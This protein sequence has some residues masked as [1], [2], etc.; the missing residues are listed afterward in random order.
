MARLEVRDVQTLWSGT[1]VA[2]ASATSGGHNWWNTSNAFTS[3]ATQV[4][5]AAWFKIPLHGAERCTIFWD[6]QVGGTVGITAVTSCIL[7]G[8][9]VG[10]PLGVSATPPQ[11]GSDLLFADILDMGK[12]A[13]L[14]LLGRASDI[15]A[16]AN[17]M[18]IAAT[19]ADIGGGGTSL[20]E[21]AV[22]HAS[23]GGET[24]VAGNVTQWSLPVFDPRKIVSASDFT[25][26]GVPVDL[27]VGHLGTV[28]VGLK[29]IST[30]TGSGATN[31]TGTLKALKYNTITLVDK[32]DRRATFR[33]D[34]RQS[35]APF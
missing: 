5:T 24:P 12:G 13:T 15:T 14:G 16:D 9:C 18:A 8:V 21:A 31:I 29:F 3:N 35:I 30:H 34:K 22:F 33:V 1:N 26:I 7:K 10:V 2:L 19:D 4:P 23:A 28:W 25:A 20:S 6:G 17:D 27:D 11:V 32:I